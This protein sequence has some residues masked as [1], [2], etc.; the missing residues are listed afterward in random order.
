MP[1][2]TATGSQRE[3]T[4]PGFPR[5]RMPFSPSRPTVRPAKTGLYPRDSIPQTA[6]T[7]S[8]RERT[9]PGFPRSRM[10]FSPS[11]SNRPTCEGRHDALRWLLHLFLH[12]DISI[13]AFL[14]ETVAGRET[15]DSTLKHHIPTAT[16]CRRPRLISCE[17]RRSREHYKTRNWD[18]GNALYSPTS[19]TLST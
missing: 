15:R 7:G 9:V 8:Q 17:I 18:E 10:P 14:S 19:N 16:A 13:K 12:R 11:R 5:S 6:A 3:R 4:V 1:Q 2:T